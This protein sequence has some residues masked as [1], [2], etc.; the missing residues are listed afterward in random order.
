M[1]WDSGAGPGNAEVLV[2]AG[3]F[4][5]DVLFIE[6]IRVLKYLRRFKSSDRM[7]GKPVPPSPIKAVATCWPSLKSSQIDHWLT[8]SLP[9]AGSRRKCTAN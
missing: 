1:I 4:D 7:W 2:V 6:E 8:F 9:V 5:I 3:A